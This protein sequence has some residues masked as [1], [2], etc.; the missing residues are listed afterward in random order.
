[1]TPDGRIADQGVILEIEPKR[2]LVLTWKNELFSDIADEGYSRLS[3]EIET[4]GESVKLTVCHEID[5][6]DSKLI[7]GVSTG[8]P[9]ILSSLKSLLET[10]ESL[11]ETRQWPEGI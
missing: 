11:K 9:H 3:Y 4:E 5:K 6:P 10:G 2:K 1:M 7:R 8:W